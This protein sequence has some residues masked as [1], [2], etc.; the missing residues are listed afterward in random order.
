MVNGASASMTDTPAKQWEGITQSVG[1]KRGCRFPVVQLAGLF[2]LASGPA[3][4]VGF[5][6]EYVGDDS[7]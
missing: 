1:Q 3:A 6:E 2:C 7:R 4:G 5:Q